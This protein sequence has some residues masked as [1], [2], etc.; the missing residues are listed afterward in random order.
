VT[1]LRR[2]H[3]GL[4]ERLEREGRVAWVAEEMAELADP[5]D[6]PH[7]SR[8]GVGRLRPRSHNRRFSVA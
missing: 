3:T 7:R 8:D 2:I 6:L 4:S 5:R 1:H